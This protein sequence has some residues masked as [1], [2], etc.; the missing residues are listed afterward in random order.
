MLA[1]NSVNEITAYESGEAWSH[2]E[3]SS[4]LILRAQ[5]IA[6]KDIAISLKRT[7]NACSTKLS[8][9]LKNFRNYRHGLSSQARAAYE[10]LKGEQPQS[11]LPSETK[12]P[13]TPDCKAQ[14]GA[15]PATGK[16]LGEAHIAVARAII[17][18][19]LPAASLLIYSEKMKVA[20]LK[21]ITDLSE[22]S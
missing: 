6:Y 10:T 11:L 7:E 8:N 9:V 20:M 16:I 5:N 21:L 1:Q 22:K 19:V 2:I 15:E 14:C 12:K 17:N 4:L 18:G 13:R 3:I